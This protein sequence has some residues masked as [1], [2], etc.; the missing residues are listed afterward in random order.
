M[1]PTLPD[2]TVEIPHLR[3]IRRAGLWTLQPAEHVGPGE[4]WTR[5]HPTLRDAVDEA[6]RESTTK[7]SA[8]SMVGQPVVDG[9]WLNGEI[10]DIAMEDPDP[11]RRELAGLVITATDP[12]RRQRAR[13]AHLL[14]AACGFG[15]LH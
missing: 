15:R 14:A 7:G 5:P 9:D 13:A 11:L 3:A 1:R 2:I 12:M 8:W 4:D 10:F 6:A